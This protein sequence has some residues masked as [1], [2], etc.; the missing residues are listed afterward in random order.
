MRIDEM[1]SISNRKIG[2]N[3]P[4]FIIAELSGNHNQSIEKALK[5]VDAAADSEIITS[6][7]AASITLAVKSCLDELPACFRNC[8]DIL[9]PLKSK[10]PE[11][12]DSTKL[13]V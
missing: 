8:A 3:Q 9:Y 2:K 10:G 4:P 11:S 5:I 12:S 7:A 1:F 6:P 13:K